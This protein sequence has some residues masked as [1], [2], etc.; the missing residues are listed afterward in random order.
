MDANVIVYLLLILIG[1][2][3]TVVAARWL[4]KINAMEAYQKSSM[5]LLKNIAEKSGV[6][7]S[8]INE[9]LKPYYDLKKGYV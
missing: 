8:E 1:V 9:S 5:F 4:F 6:S 2:G 3:V 7:Q